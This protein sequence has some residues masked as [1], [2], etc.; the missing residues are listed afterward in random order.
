MMLLVENAGFFLSGTLRTLEL[1]VVILLCATLV[2]AIVGLMSV[3]R[4]RR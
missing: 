1:A 4:F 2:S 3:S